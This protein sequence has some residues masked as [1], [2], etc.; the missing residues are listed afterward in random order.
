M[1]KILFIIIVSLL[2]FSNTYLA[3][4]T[5]PT[6]EQLKNDPDVLWL[7]VIT[8]DYALNYRPEKATKKEQEAMKKLGIKKYNLYKTL[9]LQQVATDDYEGIYPPSLAQKILEKKEKNAF[10][11]ASLTQLYT[12]EELR[13]NLLVTRNWVT[14]DPETFA[15]ILKTSIKPATPNQVKI[16]RVKQII[17]YSKKAMAFKTIPL[18]AAPSVIDERT[19][20]LRYLF[21]FKPN[22]LT[23]TPPLISPNISWAKRSYMDFSWD[24]VKL[25]KETMPIAK[26]LETMVA[27]L[28]KNPTKSYLVARFGYH[29]APQMTEKEIQSLQGDIN[30]PTVFE[31]K[32][33]GS[34]R[35]FDS[36]DIKELRLIQDWVWDEE[37]K[38]LFIIDQGFAPVISRYRRDGVFFNSS[39]WFTYYSN[40][41][42]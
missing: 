23:K 7:G 13:K 28:Q 38:E 22:V 29:K 19:E 12:S 16:I 20:S 6:L 34:P 17:Y 25:I 3:N 42:K 4:A 11:D 1:K 32:Y 8:I 15:Q 27:D 39:A 36:K 5:T 31:E 33:R 41:G 26:V 24:S 9:K 18:S 21:W 10:K 30:E 14:F 40:G 2:L 37:K 35:A